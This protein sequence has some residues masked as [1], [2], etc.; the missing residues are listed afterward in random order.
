MAMKSSVG[1]AWPNNM[2]VLGAEAYTILT[3][4]PPLGDQIS[5]STRGKEFEATLRVLKRISLYSNYSINNYTIPRVQLHDGSLFRV[6][7][8]IHKPF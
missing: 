4:E 1:T 3:R 7:E 6:I 2:L 8:T 5:I